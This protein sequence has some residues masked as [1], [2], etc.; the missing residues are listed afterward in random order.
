MKNVH[1]GWVW[2]I[3]AK[4]YPRFHSGPFRHTYVHRY[5][6][7][8]KLGRPLKRDE[9]VHHHD[10][11]KLNFSGKNLK[12]LGSAVHGWVSA[13]QAFWM[14]HLDIKAEASYIAYFEA[15]ENGG[16]IVNCGVVGDME[17]EQ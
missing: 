12:V 11:D 17:A 1:N 15:E 13:K 16:G 4:G 2:H 3:S 6:A 10:G 9:E 7:A 5:E 14:K 8:K